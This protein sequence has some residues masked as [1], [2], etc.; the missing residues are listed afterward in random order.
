MEV[1]GLGQVSGCRLLEVSLEIDSRAESPK[2]VQG[3]EH[4]EFW[5]S[6][7]GSGFR[8]EFQFMA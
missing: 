2:G 1:R 5:F 7:P 4:V 3:A 6:S 8:G